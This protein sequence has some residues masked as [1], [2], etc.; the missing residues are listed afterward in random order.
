MEHYKWEYDFENLLENPEKELR[1]FCEDYN[2]A[3]EIENLPD[4][5]V[6][7]KIFDFDNQGQKQLLVAY[8]GWSLQELLRAMWFYSGVK[9][10][11]DFRAR[12]GPTK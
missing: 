6:G 1:T 2:H 4:G 5:R 12:N 8:S 10:N 11:Y 7:V 3:Y 9:F